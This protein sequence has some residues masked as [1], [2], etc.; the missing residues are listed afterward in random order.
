MLPIGSVGM[1]CGVT[2]WPVRGAREAQIGGGRP[3]ESLLA[4]NLGT[5]GPKSPVAKELQG[6]AFGSTSGCI[7][8]ARLAGE[9]EPMAV[10]LAGDA[11]RA[12]TTYIAPARVFL[13]LVSCDIDRSRD[14]W[15][16]P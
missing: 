12:G 9:N 3:Q 6:D 4:A 1:L 15:T 13:R 8:L 7:I 11:I 14:S 10:L 2:M 16:L 5:P